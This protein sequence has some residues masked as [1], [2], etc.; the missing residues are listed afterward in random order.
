VGTLCFVIVPE[1]GCDIALII[2]NHS[3]DLK[4]LPNAFNVPF[5]VT[6]LQKDT[7]G[8]Q[9]AKELELMQAEGIDLVWHVT[10]RSFRT[11]LSYLSTQGHQRLFLARLCGQQSPYHRALYERGVKLIGATAARHLR[12]ISTKGPFWGRLRRII[13]HRDEVDDLLRRADSWKRMCWYA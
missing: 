13:S 4:P 3:E 12:Q 2:S 11:P 8:R 9:E 10:C 6:K 5:H 7:K 1:V